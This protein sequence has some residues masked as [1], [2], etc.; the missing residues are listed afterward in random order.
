MMSNQKPALNPKVD[1]D[2]LSKETIGLPVFISDQGQTV[3][4]DSTEGGRETSSRRGSILSSKRLSKVFDLAI[5]SLDNLCVQTIKHAQTLL[6]DDT[7]RRVPRPNDL[8]SGR[9]D[10]GRFAE[11]ETYKDWLD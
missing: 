11:E 5:T 4:S 6:A 8:E 1:I 10:N 7:P 9:W 3:T 2:I